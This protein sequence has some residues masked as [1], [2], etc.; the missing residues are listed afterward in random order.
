MQAKLIKCTLGFII[1]HVCICVQLYAQAGC[2]LVVLND[3]GRPFSNEN[4]LLQK[5]FSDT[6][7]CFK[8][9]EDLTSVLSLQ[10]YITASVD[11]VWVNSD[12]VF[13]TLYLGEK[14]V[15]DQLIIND[16]LQTILKAGGIKYEKLLLQPQS[17]QYIYNYLLFYYANTGHPFA[18]VYLDSTLINGNSVRARLRV[19]HGPFY[20]MDSIMVDGDARI[21]GNFLQHYL[22]IEKMYRQKILDEIN[23][24]LSKL[25][26][27]RQ[28]QPWHVEMLNTGAILHLYLEPTT[29]NEIDVLIGLLPSNQQTGKL[30]LTGE[31]KALLQN[32]FGSGETLSL[33]WQ[34]LQPGSPQL[35]VYVQR[36]YVFSSKYGVQA[37]FN[38]YKRDSAFVLLQGRGGIQYNL[39]SQKT[40]SV[41]FH[42]SSSNALYT[43]TQLV[44]ITRQLPE[45]GDVTTWGVGL[46]FF[47]TATD[48]RFNPR[49]GN[50]WFLSGIISNK[51]I[52]KNTSIT[53]ITDPEFDF[54]S[55]YDSVKMNTYQVKVQGSAAHYIP[56]GRQAT[57][58]LALQ[59]GWLKTPAYYQN[60][61][62]R[63]GGFRLLR[64]FD[65]ES[66]YTNL[67]GVATVEY[68][69]LLGRNSWFYGF[70]DAGSTQNKSYLTTISHGYLGFGTGLAL[71]T[72]AG[73]LNIS[74]AEGKRND[75][76]LD[77]RQT[78][79][80]LGFI[81][82]F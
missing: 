62:F 23:D 71:E 60:E 73:V 38:L 65:E 59:G 28:Y 16:T 44:K 77:F 75:T 78:K 81:S 46:D 25:T 74:I 1:M 70:I 21:S 11:S 53:K 42:T 29:N 8:Y 58:K 51:H 56:A 4:V 79:I 34:Q 57:I 24:K 10:G 69:Y 7:Q 41:F 18:R 76:R 30:L 67:Y 22:G 40:G 68:R 37:N 36:P 27:L 49:S 32:S 31:A 52:A 55:L 63:V 39:S 20:T 17:L 5:N 3:E 15:L 54:N 26:F 33:K 12:T 14:Y 6:A 9:V 82:L 50:E 61:M 35:D 2:R 45:T 66:I 80:H 47:T 72:K 48:Y 19:D 43:D 64:G 13:I